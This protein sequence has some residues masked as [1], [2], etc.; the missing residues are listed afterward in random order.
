MVTAT[1][2]PTERR[3]SGISR[4]SRPLRLMTDSDPESLAEARRQIRQAMNATGLDPE[5]TGDMELAASEAL[6]N[7]HR[8][9]YPRT[10]GPVFVEVC[11][12]ILSVVVVIIDHGGATDAPPIPS[13]QPSRTQ[14][15]GRG[16]YLIGQLVDACSIGVSA[17]G[18][19]L[20]V[21]LAKWLSND[22]GFRPL[23]A[24]RDVN[25]G[26][27]VGT[28]MVL[29][30]RAHEAIRRSAELV[31]MSQQAL[32]VTRPVIEDA[33]IERLEHQIARH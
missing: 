26:R 13:I 29:S 21:V 32:A 5:A 20:V 9:A 19:G 14:Y 8:H 3:H 28:A 30:I 10:I 11:R 15:G 18:H 17:T 24:R 6:S 22:L 12:T 2:P 25:Q 31:A 4:V 23:P 1:A 7:T 16:L 27:P 33:R